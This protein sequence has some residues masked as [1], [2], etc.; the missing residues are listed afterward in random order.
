MAFKPE[1]PQWKRNSIKKFDM[2]TYT[3]IFFQFPAD[4]V[5][6][7]TSTQFFLYADPKTRGYFPVWQSLDG[8]GF[9]PVS[10]LAP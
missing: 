1:L 5:F 4:K 7:N 6:W 3:K 9:H 10:G 8:P 2:G